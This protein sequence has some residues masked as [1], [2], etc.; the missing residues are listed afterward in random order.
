MVTRYLHYLGNDHV[1]F[2]ATWGL[3]VGIVVQR[4]PEVLCRGAC[5]RAPLQEPSGRAALHEVT[6][7]IVRKHSIG[8]AS[9]EGNVGWQWVATQGGRVVGDVPLGRVAEASLPGEV[10]AFGVHPGSKGGERQSQEG[11]F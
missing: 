5:V 10:D 2:I 1:T 7:H 4:V 3:Q 8:V 6:H 9:V 11:M